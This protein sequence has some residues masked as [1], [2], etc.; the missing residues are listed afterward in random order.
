[1]KESFNEWHYIKDYTCKFRAKGI[2]DVFMD[3]EVNIN[4][5]N[6][7]GYAMSTLTKERTQRTIDSIIGKLDIDADFGI[8]TVCYNELILLIRF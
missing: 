7:S 6:S 2:K 1:M 8:W 5:R 3:S 4:E